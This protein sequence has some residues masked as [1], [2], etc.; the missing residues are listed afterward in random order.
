M[1]E[2]Q[3][4]NFFSFALRDFATADR[5]AQAIL[6]WR[7]ADSIP[8]SNGAE[9]DQY[10]REGYLALPTNQTFREVTDLLSVMGVTPEIF[11]RVSPYLT[12][13]GSGVVNVNSADT[14]VLKAVPGMTDEM[15]A[16]I[17]SQRSMGRR[18][19]NL[20]QVTPR[21]QGLP[22]GINLPGQN[23]GMTV[24]VSE[25][26]LTLTAFVGPQQLPVRL[27]AIIQRQGANSQI[28][29]RQW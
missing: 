26:Q 27:N 6:D 29:W 22:A 3:L 9:R 15:L 10:I 14:L 21:R 11:E 18:I 25:L 7:D 28:T 20:N 5:I 12:T 23:T 8:R 13:R 2:G 4:R 19:S 17:L 16:Q 1:G 24:D